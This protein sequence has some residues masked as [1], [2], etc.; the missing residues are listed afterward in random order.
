MIDGNKQDINNTTFLK[1]N[2]PGF[3]KEND[4]KLCNKK[5]KKQENIQLRRIS[6]KFYE[7]E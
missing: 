3:N 1:R 7:K 2:I 5:I 6:E 4:I